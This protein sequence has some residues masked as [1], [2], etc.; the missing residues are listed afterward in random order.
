MKQ[1]ILTTCVCLLTLASSFAQ[2]DNYTWR[3]TA[4]SG[5]M[6]Y[7]GDLS[8]DRLYNPQFALE[9]WKEQ[10]KNSSFGLAI[11]KSLS[12]GMGLQLLYQ[13]G[14]FRSTDRHIEFDGDPYLD[15]ENYTRA[16]NVKTDVQ[17]LSLIWMFYGD[18]GRFLN[19][20]IFIAPYLGVGVGVTKFDPYADLTDA[21]GNYYNYWSDGSVRSRPENDPF[22]AYAERVEL[23]GDFETELRPL[24]TEGEEYGDFTMSFPLVWGLKFRLGERFNLNLE[25]QARY[26][27]TD[28][29]DDV[30]GKYLLTY[31]SPEQLQAAVPSG[32]ISNTNLDR[33]NPD[34]FLKKDV[35]GM[36]SISLS[37]NFGYKPD[38]FIAPI[39]YPLESTIN[40]DVT[41]KDVQ[42][43]TVDSIIIREEVYIIIDQN[44]DTISKRIEKTI[45]SSQDTDQ[46]IEREIKIRMGD[47]PKES[48]VD[49]IIT[50]DPETG[51]ET[52]MII[53]SEV[54]GEEKIMT[55]DVDKT[56]IE[57]MTWTEQDKE[58]V[59]IQEIVEEQQVDTMVVFDPAT[60]I[61]TW[62]LI[63]DGKQEFLKRVQAQPLL[64]PAPEQPRSAA[65]QS[66]DER[67]DDIRE[68]RKELLELNG[69]ILEMR[70][71]ERARSQQEIDSVNARINVL[72]SRLDEYKSYNMTTGV[73]Y[74]SPQNR[75]I[76]EQTGEIERE[77]ITVRE[78]AKKVDG[79]TFVPIN[80]EE[81]RRTQAQNKAKIEALE[82]Q[83][84]EAQS[85][86]PANVIVQPTQQ[87]PQR[88]EIIQ[89]ELTD[90]PFK[91]NV[92]SAAPATIRSYDSELQDINR[93][94][95]DISAAQSRGVEINQNSKRAYENR[96]RTLEREIDI[97]SRNR[98]NQQT[99]LDIKLL[100]AKLD[101]INS[102][103]GQINTP[104]PT[105]R[106]TVFIERA[107]PTQEPVIIEKVVEKPVVVEK[108]VER[109]VVVE[110]VIEKPI[111]T[112]RTI[113]K[114]PE[115]S[116]AARAIDAFGQFNIFFESGKSLPKASD[117]NRL[118]GAIRLMQQYPDI[119]ILLDGYADKK[120]SA[121]KNFT[122]SKERAENIKRYLT[123]QGISSS[124][125][126][127]AFYGASNAQGLND[128]FARRV[129]IRLVT[130]K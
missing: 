14:S 85:R 77:M 4:K 55:I 54:K 112:E 124:R 123:S 44:G 61:E 37:Y 41:G 42:K 24:K 121:E 62:F 95:S 99:A 111:V 127:T 67:V 12:Q 48:S 1:Y 88:I 9:D 97:L 21:D 57:N 45:E 3:I 84:A 25:G 6:S 22:S 5:M 101:K 125:I 98:T 109:P 30:S 76:R 60:G 87:T 105:R 89:P 66:T 68:L 34:R 43:A 10:Y 19:E 75:I 2:Q 50:F 28:Y 51:E 17:D 33:G 40:V 59:K 69:S 16:L 78:E 64:A 29:L 35:Y 120:G 115:V 31:D 129:A 46:Q 70:S 119:N 49:T 81:Y 18:N 130:A 92:S 71:Q 114:E 53:R 106:D 79:P 82:R 52:I 126:Q 73:D 27:L 80:L 32:V 110:K 91:Q 8:S 107:A 102:Q 72:Q 90:Q 96:I 11:E 118:D 13:N 103:L 23:D 15:Y 100:Q 117:L 56:D 108:I 7:Y 39:I 122:I 20:K 104:Q 63:K 93:Q 65:P 116:A 128:P 58:P 74:N 113:I 26:T 36:G 86:K 38:A 94:L 47:L 83:L